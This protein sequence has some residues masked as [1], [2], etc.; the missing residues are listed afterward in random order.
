[1]TDVD[2]YHVDPRY[3]PIDVKN[4]GE[5][6]SILND[7]LPPKEVFLGT[8]MLMQDSDN[9]FDLPPKERLEIFKHV[10]GLIGIDE[11][12]D[13][14]ADKKREY[15]AMIKARSDL[16]QYDDKLRIGMTSLR[17]LWTDMVA[18]SQRY[19]RTEA[20]WTSRSAWMNDQHLL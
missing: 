10:F 5:L 8:V 16:S 20:A 14:I 12:K 7:L 15:G 19:T 1:M 13:L 18:Q 4:E 6:Q 17:E 2:L 9:I 3:E 11:S